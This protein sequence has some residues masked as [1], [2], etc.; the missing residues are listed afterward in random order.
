MF[1]SKGAQF[2]ATV[3]SRFKELGLE[4]D[5]DIS[6]AGGPSSTTMTKM[7]AVV[8]DDADMARPRGDTRRRI[9]TAA[10]WAPGSAL[11]V[12]EGGSP[13]AQEDVSG[14]P[15]FTTWADMQN[16]RY[17]AKHMARRI[18]ELDE[19]LDALRRLVVILAADLEQLRGGNLVDPAAGSGA[20]LDQVAARRG[21]SAGQQLRRAQ[22]EA[23]E[24][25]QDD[26]A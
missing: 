20:F 19:E 4:T 7:R 14:D 2:A 11:A 17:D 1:A 5:E 22:D 12:W 15:G 16:P 8:N 13:T 6:R 18:D 25:S 21:A 3:I 23:G 26:E 24:E 10:K 9:E